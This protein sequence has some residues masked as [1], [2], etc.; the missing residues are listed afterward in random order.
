MTCSRAAPRFAQTLAFVW[1]ASLALSACQVTIEK[2]VKGRPCAPDDQNLECLPDEVC[3]GG[4]CRAKEGGLD[5]DSG[6]SLDTGPALDGGPAADRDSGPSPD[7]EPAFDGGPGADAGAPRDDGGQ[8]P[9]LA[10]LSGAFDDSAVNG[11]FAQWRG[12]SVTIAGVWSDATPDDQEQLWSL[13]RSAWTSWTGAL[14]VAVGAIYKD[15]AA[16][17]EQAAQR[18]YPQ[19]TWQAA[20]KG[21]YDSRWKASL[22][23]LQKLRSAAG[24]GTTY[25]RFAAGFN[26]S[27]PGMACRWS[28]DQSDL[29]DFKIA[30]KNFR[31]F[32]KQIF[33]DARLVWSPTDGT[34]TDI[35][36]RDAFPD[37]ADC[38]DVIGVMA[39]NEYPFA[40][41]A[42]EFTKK[43]NT[44]A[45]GV[46]LGSNAPRGVETWRRF[47][48]GKGLPF[49]LCEW[50]SRA[51]DDGYGSG[52]GD[53]TDYFQGVHDWLVANAG[54]AP[55]KV[56]Y[57][58]LFN[59]FK[60]YALYRSDGSQT[61]Q[62]NAAA[63]YR[64][65]W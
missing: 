57:E 9:A 17:P 16:C 8:G 13:Q 4:R 10:W 40:A 18:T 61:L 45:R 15:Y 44:D 49:A 2:G 24:M 26:G 5:R 22:T 65:L 59:L 51:K 63:K 58:V 60:D 21:A 1:L 11:K 46:A 53:S 25:I 52:G 6:P 35:D 29:A 48:Q 47:A 31:G 36:V 55:G 50:G 64:E 38:V 42:E 23:K 41:T 27:W 32:Q 62:P 54:T 28:V 30:W 12:T 34:G 19:E 33:P 3:Q 39:K 20:A 7:A 37:C 43:W 56:E 14:D